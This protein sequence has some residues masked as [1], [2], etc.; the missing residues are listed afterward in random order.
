[1]DSAYKIFVFW[2]WKPEK[3]KLIELIK[4]HNEAN[5][6]DN[7]PRSFGNLFAQTKVVFSENYR[8]L[9]ASLIHAV[10]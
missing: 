8:E 10:Y 6:T 5:K 3:Q 9:K 1:M 7:A 4:I 2:K